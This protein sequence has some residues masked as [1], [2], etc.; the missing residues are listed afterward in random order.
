MEGTGL[1]S[2]HGCVVHV[3]VRMESKLCCGLL[4][5]NSVA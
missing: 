5:R 1:G 3:D 2:A 4:Q